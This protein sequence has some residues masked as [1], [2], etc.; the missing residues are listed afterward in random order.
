MRSLYFA[1]GMTLLG[2]STG[3]SAGP[4]DGGGSIDKP[5]SPDG[6]PDS[7]APRSSSATGNESCGRYLAC[8]LVTSPEAYGAAIQI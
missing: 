4:S 6:G 7:S 1:V 8:L 5:S 3:S 2:C